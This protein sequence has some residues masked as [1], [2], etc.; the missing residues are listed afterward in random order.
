[1]KERVHFYSTS[2]TS[3]SFNLQ[4]ATPVIESFSEDRVYVDINEVIELYHIRQFVN[5]DITLKEW[6]EDFIAKTES[7]NKKVAS[8]FTGINPND[9]VAIYNSV[10][11]D[12]TETFWKIV[13]HFN[14]RG[15][16][17]EENLKAVAEGDLYT[18]RDILRCGK[19]VK[20]YNKTISALL[21]DH[22]NT[23]EWLLDHYVAKHELSPIEPI[24]IP[25]AL[26]LVE[27][28]EIISKYLDRGVDANLNYVQLVINAKDDKTNFTLSPKTRLK[29][30][31]LEQEQIRQYFKPGMGVPMR[32]TVQMSRKEGIEPV[33]CFTD[34][35]G[36]FVRGYDANLIDKLSY[37]DIIYYFKYVFEYLSRMS[38]INQI[39]M[40]SQEGVMERV[41]GLS[42]KDTYRENLDFKMK[43]QLVVVQM[44]SMVNVLKETGKRVEDAIKSFY[45]DHLKKKYGYPAQKIT[46][47]LVES[48]YVEKFRALA[49]ELDALVK[50]YNLYSKEDEIDPE[51]LVLESSI[52]VT[53][54]ASCVDKKYFVANENNT[55]LQTLFNLLMG[56]QSMLQYVEPFKDERHH[57]FLSLLITMR[58]IDCSKYKQW[59]LNRLQPLIDKG[60]VK[61]GEDSI[62]QVL[63]WPKIIVLQHLY[64]YKACP[65]WHYPAEMQ[66]VILD[67]EKAGWVTSYNRLL[68]PEEQNYFS[69]ILNNERFTNAYA[70]RNCYAHGNNAPADEEQQHEVAYTRL[71]IMFVLLLLKI[72]DDLSLKVALEQSLHQHGT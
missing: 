38:F 55:D 14:I 57:S 48:S 31:K 11:F 22:A 62:L 33:F 6:N 10:E 19:I 71:L 51:L 30:R 65:F 18:L 7:F 44:T 25:S 35:E 15:I 34:E 41:M 52:K 2:D 4:L 61:I 27:K 3:I 24:I 40:S 20:W 13:D 49:P 36:H 46:V 68:T 56:D 12:Y 45:E 39:S 43:D 21:K 1:M 54:S 67:M 8:F 9:L 69:F 64:K 66:K 58:P 70:I 26:S 16:L 23:A 37:S 63:D 28:E 60:I 50:Q 72:D 29:A 59:K 42:A 5:S 17:N 32:T 47:P 53:D